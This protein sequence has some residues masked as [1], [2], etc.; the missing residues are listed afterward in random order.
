[1]FPDEVNWVL[2]AIGLGGLLVFLK[3][4][5]FV[6]RRVRYVSIVFGYKLK[7]ILSP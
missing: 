1:M 5:R 3:I 7:S 6:W 4:G 2:F